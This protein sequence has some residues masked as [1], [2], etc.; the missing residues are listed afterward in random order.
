MVLER[1]LGVRVKS[2]NRSGVRK[3]SGRAGTGRGMYSR[4]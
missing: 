2:K 1:V 3:V 4:S